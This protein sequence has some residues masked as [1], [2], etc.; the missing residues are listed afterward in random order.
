MVKAMLSEVVPER[1]G[2]IGSAS[3][4]GTGPDGPFGAVPIGRAAW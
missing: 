3:C 2:A 4:A 1:A